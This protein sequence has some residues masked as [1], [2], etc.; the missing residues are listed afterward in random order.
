M[1][2]GELSRSALQKMIA[3]KWKIEDDSAWQEQ[4][5]MPDQDLVLIGFPGLAGTG[6]VAEQKEE[7]LL[8]WFSRPFVEEAHQCLE[9]SLSIPEDMTAGCQVS[10][11]QLVLEGG[12]YRALWELAKKAG[13]GLEIS[14]EDIVM[15]QQTIELCEKYDL[16]PYQLLSGGCVLVATSQG[17]KLIDTLQRRDIP[18]RI[19]GHTTASR[20]KLI[21]RQG[22]TGN[23]E[24]SR[25]DE[26]YKIC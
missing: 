13:I 25:Q 17:R 21:Y 4:Y 16:N 19:I 20:E 2:T 10:A 14:I 6:I 8:Q 3:T 23:L 15:K 24:A 18:A 11:V 7:Q 26:L 12:I 22:K 9:M 5:A 1:E